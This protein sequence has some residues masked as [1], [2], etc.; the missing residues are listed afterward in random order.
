ML[1]VVAAA[2]IRQSAETQTN[3][4]ACRQVGDAFLKAGTALGLKVRSIVVEQE[5]QSVAQRVPCDMARLTVVA[6]EPFAF[7][8]RLLA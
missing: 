2:D 1:G 6:S 5:N 4:D 8:P 3:A 7:D